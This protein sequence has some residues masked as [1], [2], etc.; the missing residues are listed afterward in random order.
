MIDERK[1]MSQR[2]V[3]EMLCICKCTLISYRDRDEKPFPQ[4]LFKWKR[5]NFYDRDAVYAWCQEV[6]GGNANG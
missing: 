6:T 2:E 1:H 3:L 4:P 5:E